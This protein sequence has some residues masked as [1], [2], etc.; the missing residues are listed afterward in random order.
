[1]RLTKSF[2]LSTAVACAIQA[3]TAHAGSLAD[4]Y[5]QAVSQ[6]PQLKAAQANSQAGQEILPQTRA[7]LLPEVNLSARTSWNES[8]IQNDF[9]NHGY[10]VSLSQP[11]FSAPAWY[12][13]KRGQ[14]LSEG[15]AL[16][17]DQAQQDLIQRT[18]EDYLTVLRAINNLETSQAEERAVQ[19]RLDQVNAQFEVGL[20][21]ITD[22]QE[23][24]ATY[25]N[26]KVERI[27]AEGDLDNS[28]EALDRL[29]GQTYSS[30]DLLSEEYPI[31]NP[32]PLESAPWL[33]KANAG[34]LGLKIADVNVE[35]ARRQAQFSRSGH[36]PE[37]FLT[38]SYDE[39]NGS[40]TTIDS[41]DRSTIALRLTVPLYAGGAISSETREDEYR[42]TEA[43]QVRE[44]TFRALTQNTRSLLRDLRTDVLSVAARKQS[45]K[46]SQ[47]ALKATEEGFSVGTRNVVDV[48]DAERK[49]YTAQRD[50]ATARFDYVQNLID[51]KQQIGTLGPQD[52]LGLDQWMT[53]QEY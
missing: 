14:A 35:A 41:T 18:V 51:F 49:L 13:F 40:A 52:L 36:L 25:D 37:V 20:I 4:I 22:V 53:A 11:V 15:A 24:Q 8:S 38:A 28:Y 44:D 12:G 42:Y 26:T 34:N 16:Q 31:E 3:T 50:Y 9:N 47:T 17:Y 30:I 19:R 10:T 7:E 33:E 39:S 46:S 48:L 32:T 23:A 6:D 29:T 5:N 27:L 1:M 21:A 45:I 2:W 43:Q